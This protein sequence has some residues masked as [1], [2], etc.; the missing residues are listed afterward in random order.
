LVEYLKS[1]HHSQPIKIKVN[2]SKE[3]AFVLFDSVSPVEIL[4]KQKAIRFK[5]RTTFITSFLGMLYLWKLPPEISILNIQIELD[6]F[7]HGSKHV[8]KLDQ[9]GYCNASV[10]VS[11]EKCYNDLLKV[12]I[13]N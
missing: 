10:I 7:G 1:F 8:N 2:E 5:Q 12:V 9:E 13:S 11:S 4:L 3:I 6:K